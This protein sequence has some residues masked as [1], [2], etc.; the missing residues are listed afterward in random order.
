ML[1]REVVETYIVVA[2][3]SICASIRSSA[4]AKPGEEVGDGVAGGVTGEVSDISDS[5]DGSDADTVRIGELPSVT[6]EATA[7]FVCNR[8]NRDVSSCAYHVKRS[9]YQPY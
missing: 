1:Q 7:L 5:E 8:Y 2:H 3:L 4:A 6:L 9:I